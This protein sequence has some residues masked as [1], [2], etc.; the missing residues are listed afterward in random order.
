M[1]KPNQPKVVDAYRT[2]PIGTQKT[3]K[4]KKKTYWH[5]NA[6]DANS[7]EGVLLRHFN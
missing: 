3:K 5:S 7:S 6:S 1:R 4:K 2:S